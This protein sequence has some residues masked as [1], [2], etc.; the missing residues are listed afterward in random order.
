MKHVKN[1]TEICYPMNQKRM[2]HVL[3]V[4]NRE[5]YKKVGTKR[6]K[7]PPREGTERDE[8]KRRKVFESLG[9]KFKVEANATAKVGC[10]SWNFFPVAY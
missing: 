5:F 7:K 10:S 4:N 9:F 8:E 3:V 2:G 1:F 6:I